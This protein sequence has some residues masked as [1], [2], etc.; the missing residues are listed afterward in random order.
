[1]GIIALRADPLFTFRCTLT[2]CE[3]LLGTLG[4]IKPGLDLVCS[5]YRV[6]ATFG[7]EGVTERTASGILFTTFPVFFVTY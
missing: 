5:D 2:E 4:D 7:A 1:M 3:L 6:R